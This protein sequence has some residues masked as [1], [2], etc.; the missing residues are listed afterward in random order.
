[1]S[2][3]DVD[4]ADSGVGIAD[5]V[6]DTRGAEAFACDLSLSADGLAAG[7]RVRGV[8]CRLSWIVCSIQKG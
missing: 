1:M 4:I 5:M 7:L 3:A 6:L 8:A 2:L